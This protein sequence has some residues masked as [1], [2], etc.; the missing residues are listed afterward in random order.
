M[1]KI[2]AV[3]N[4]KGGGGKTTSSV[5]IADSLASLNKKTLLIDLD[6]QANASK[7]LRAA[8]KSP[9]I[10][11]ALLGGKNEYS[12]KDLIYPACAGDQEIPNFYI[13]PAS[14][15]RELATTAE[16]MTARKMREQI[17]ERFMK[18]NRDTFKEFDYII[19]D[20]N[21]S[22]SCSYSECHDGFR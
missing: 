12:A 15:D 7:R 9:N 19:I 8:T 1:T 2:L 18:K 4:Q 22:L 10:N 14:S 21:P 5:N 3:T 11:D 20:T 17:L 13:L 6:P 16:V